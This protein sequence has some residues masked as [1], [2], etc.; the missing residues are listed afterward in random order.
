MS[1]SGWASRPASVAPGERARDACGFDPKPRTA[2]GFDLNA[3]F[4]S[5]SSISTAAR[6]T[7][8]I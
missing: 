3:T 2:Q 8:K 7:P 4:A 5:E 1:R 6:V